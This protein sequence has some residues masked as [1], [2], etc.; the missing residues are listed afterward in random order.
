MCAERV[1]PSYFMFIAAVVYNIPYSLPHS[2][3]KTVFQKREFRN[4]LARYDRRIPCNSST[5]TL[6]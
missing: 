4:G 5:R 3:G 2:W 1:L 6:P